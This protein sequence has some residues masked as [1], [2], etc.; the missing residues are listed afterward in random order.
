MRDEIY[1]RFLE[2]IPKD[3]EIAGTNIVEFYALNQISDVQ[4]A[5]LCSRVAVEILNR[6]QLMRAEHTD[7]YT[8]ARAEKIVSLE[9][10]AAEFR[11]YA[12][13]AILEI[14]RLVSLGEE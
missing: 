6:L 10:L 8:L 4:F 14:N 11:G 5:R 9:R 13:K 2:E 12:A 3:P 1:K 7:A